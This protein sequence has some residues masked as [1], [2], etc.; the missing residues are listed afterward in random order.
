MTAI[1]FQNNEPASFTLESSHL[2]GRIAEA[3]EFIAEN[4]AEQPDLDT[5]A[6]HIGMSPHHFQRTFSDWAGVSPK[7]FLKAIT[8]QDAKERLRESE[9]V[10]D[11]SF[12]A[13]LS[14]PG[15]LHDLFVT[16]DAV[17]PGEYKSRG[18]GMTF[19]YGIHP[20]PFGPCLIVLNA[21]GLTGLSFVDSTEQ[22]AIDY[23]KEHWEKATWV[24]DETITEPFI[25]QVFQANTKGQTKNLKV[26]LR[27]SP[28]RIK[29]W[30]ALL[31]LPSGTV[32]S[33]GDLAER[34]DRPGA[35]RA[36]AGA[37]ANNRIGLV[38]PCHRVIRESGALAGYRWGET[39]KAAILGLEA[40]WP[41][42]S[43]LES[44]A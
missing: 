14:G 37:I 1:A 22:D 30:E 15:R 16:T 34:L 43:S 35:A 29:I 32:T 9:S 40:S 31:R 11:A 12:G 13:G 10:L 25:Q 6:A 36:V 33:Y 23:Q 19:T 41:S 42:S 28:F 7:K 26:L 4:Q 20:S 3:I 27:G 21:R 38:I 39:R 17:T 8:L 24:R 2:Y 5:V 18:A 44:R